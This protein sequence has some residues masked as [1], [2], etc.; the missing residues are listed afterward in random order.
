[1]R[2]TAA[3]ARSAGEA[4]TVEHLDIEQPRDDEIL[5]RV[6]AVGLSHTD[7]LARDQKLPV[8]LP[9]VLGREGVGWVERVGA[10]VSKI[11]P[12]DHV[13]LT[14]VAGEPLPRSSCADTPLA[15]FDL[16]FSGLRP[17]GSSPLSLGGE[18]I[19]GAFFG[20]SSF[21]THAIARERNAIRVDKALPFPTIASLGGDVQ[22]GAGAVI[23]TLRPRPG[24]SIAVFGAGAVGLSAVIA[25]R[26]A[27]CH[28]IIAVDIKASRLD[29]AESLG[30]THT[31]DPDGLE[32]I[33][34]IRGITRDGAEF[35]IETT[36][37]PG[38]VRQALDCLG[39]GGACAVAGTAPLD[40]EASLSMSNLQ[41]ARCVRGS[42]FGDGMPAMFIPR[43]I[44]LHK[45]GRLPIERLVT[46][47]RL[48]RINEAADALVSGAAVKPVLV[49]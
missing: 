23:N 3:V 39:P 19:A 24:S 49:P 35:A 32:P 31:I 41:L 5:V 16:N 14:Y 25:A 15:D 40:A 30:A 33:A 44:E 18:R 29:L 47:Y 45:A 1:M 37:V 7:L 26:L 21:A 28:P 42:L 11:A 17:D 27:G 4:F 43:L 34:A 48:D 20:Q 10:A 36:G 8:P 13:I 46:E 2:I 12:G 22:T 9:A 38:V 6:G